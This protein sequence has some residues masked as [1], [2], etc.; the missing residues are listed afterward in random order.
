[1]LSIKS[2]VDMMLLLSLKLWPRWEGRRAGGHF[3]FSV[4]NPSHSLTSATVGDQ[5]WT[6]AQHWCDDLGNVDLGPFVA[7]S[8]LFNERFDG[9]WTCLMVHEQEGAK[10]DQFGDYLVQVVIGG[11]IWRNQTTGL[12]RDSAV[13]CWSLALRCSCGFLFHVESS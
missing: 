9:F 6:L 8:R 3:T 12:S 7:C 5:A 13:R 2:L 1:M 10:T 4:H 11:K